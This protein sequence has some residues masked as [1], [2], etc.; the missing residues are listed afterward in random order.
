MLPDGRIVMGE[1]SVA[2]AVIMSIIIPGLG[3]M[4]NGKIGRG[5]LF[6]LFFWTIVVYFW[7]I[8]DAYVL[9]KQNNYVWYNHIN[10]Q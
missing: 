2:L 4:Y 8:Y 3:T 10:N 1:K 9:T 6:L 5:I 7:A